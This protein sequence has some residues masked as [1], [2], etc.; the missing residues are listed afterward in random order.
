[1]PQRNFTKSFRLSRRQFTAALAALPFPAAAAKGQTLSITQSAALQTS[2]GL[3]ARPGMY[4]ENGAI[5]PDA[6][7]VALAP[8][9]AMAIFDAAT[10]AQ[11]DTVTGSANRDYTSVFSP[12]SQSLIVGSYRTLRCYDI[13][14]KRERWRTRLDTDVLWDP[15]TL[16]YRPGAVQFAVAG[17]TDVMLLVNASDGRVIREFRGHT[18]M[19]AD[20]TFINDG[21]RL[22]SGPDDAGVVIV[23]DV[24]T[25]AALQRINVTPGFWCAASLDGQHLISTYMYGAV[26]VRSLS[27]GEVVRSFPTPFTGTTRLGAAGRLRGA[28]ADPDGNWLVVAA[29]RTNEI[30]IFDWTTG[31]RLLVAPIEGGGPNALAVFPDGRTLLYGDPARVWTLE[32]S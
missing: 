31:Q 17:A 29:E 20:H 14:A 21:A 19:I 22:V 6:R 16:S 9:E 11:I 32:Q 3:Y 25:G 23:W 30:Q 4:R 28:L 26:E 2:A 27:T 15:W 18:E 12:D 10:G 1:M 7:L 13:Q 8:D 5:S 24:E